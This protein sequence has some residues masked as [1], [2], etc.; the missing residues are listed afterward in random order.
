M[1][2]VRLCLE[3]TNLGKSD[4][5]FF[6]TLDF[7]YFVCAVYVLCSIQG[8]FQNWLSVTNIEARVFLLTQLGVKFV[9]S[10]KE[11]ITPHLIKR[12]KAIKFE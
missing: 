3:D 7:S 9:P 12:K 8:L 6:F 11:S 2:K 1:R 5:F 10:V 4:F